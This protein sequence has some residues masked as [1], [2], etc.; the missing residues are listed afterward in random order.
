MIPGDKF[1]LHPDRN[2]LILPVL[3][4]SVFL[5]GVAIAYAL[6]ILDKEVNVFS[7]NSVAY[8]EKTLDGKGVYDSEGCWYCHTQQVRAVSSDLGL[9][10]VTTADRVVRDRPNV[11]GV[12]RIGPDLACYGDRQT[13]VEKVVSHLQD[14]RATIHLSNMPSYSYLSESQLEN[15]SAYL[16]GLTCGGADR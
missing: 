6:P 7:A 11:L 13:D 14:P 2:P 1:D 8:S 12:Q 5:I 3:V 4:L 15:L 10:T 16:V 9:G